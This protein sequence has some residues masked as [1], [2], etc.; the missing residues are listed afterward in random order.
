MK[1]LITILLISISIVSNGQEVETIKIGCSP[2]TSTNSVFKQIGSTKFDYFSDNG[3]GAS[4]IGKQKITTQNGDVYLKGDLYSTRGGKLNIIENKYDK[5]LYILKKEWFC[6]KYY[7]KN[8]IE[9]L[10]RN[11]Y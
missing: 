4:F 2:K 10:S 11:E 5:P 1:K 8:G 9:Y 3:T 6:F 7:T